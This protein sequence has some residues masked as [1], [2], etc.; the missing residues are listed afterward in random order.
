MHIFTNRYYPPGEEGKGISLN[1]VVGLRVGLGVPYEND[2]IYPGVLLGYQSTLL[3]LQ[4]LYKY[5]R[6]TVCRIL[7][8]DS[9]QAELMTQALGFSSSLTPPAP[10]I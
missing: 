7:L 2:V 1:A 9:V 3:H 4:A 6:L 5:V 8:V 10:N